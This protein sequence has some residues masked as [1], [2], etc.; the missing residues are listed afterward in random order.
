MQYDEIAAASLRSILKGFDSSLS[1][2]YD[3]GWRI[4]Q[5]L[6]QYALTQLF[7]GSI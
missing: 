3:I 1:N 4:S 5:V 6:W 7:P 2:E